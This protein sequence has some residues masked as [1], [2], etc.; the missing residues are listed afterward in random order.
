MIQ[1]EP[2]LVFLVDVTGLW[3]KSR[4]FRGYG[5]ICVLL[6]AALTSATASPD[7]SAVLLQVCG[8]WWGHL[9]IPHCLL[10]GFSWQTLPSFPHYLDSVQQN[11]L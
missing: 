7:P 10:D 6:H 8:K 5:Q 2:A 9:S 11:G 4:L 3:Y 1:T